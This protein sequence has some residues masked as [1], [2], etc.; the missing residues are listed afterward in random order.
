MFGIFKHVVLTFL[1][2]IRGMS[3]ERFEWEIGLL[4]YEDHVT[5]YDEIRNG[6]PEWISKELG[7]TPLPGWVKETICLLPEGGEQFL[8]YLLL[9]SEDCCRS[10][11]VG[12]Y[13]LEMAWTIRFPS[14]VGSTLTL[15]AP[16]IRLGGHAVAWFVDY[17]CKGRPFGRRCIPAGY[18]HVNQLD[19]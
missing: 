15:E 10:Y 7:L 17:Q 18:V 12:P 13:G 2:G 6:I 9:V 5:R 1:G 4:S 8:A 11:M 3:A 16:Y 14:G 19:I